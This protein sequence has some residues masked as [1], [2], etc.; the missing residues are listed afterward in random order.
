MSRLDGLA[1]IDAELLLAVAEDQRDDHWHAQAAAATLQRLAHHPRLQGFLP[2]RTVPTGFMVCWFAEQA[3]EA[4]DDVLARLLLA[5]RHLPSELEWHAQQWRRDRRRIRRARGKGLVGHIPAGPPGSG[6]PAQISIGFGAVASTR[7]PPRARSQ[8]PARRAQGRATKALK[9]ASRRSSARSGD[10]GD[11]PAGGSSKE[12]DDEPPLERRCAACV[13]LFAPARPAH[14]LCQPCHSTRRAGYSADY[15]TNRER[16]IGG[17]V[18]AAIW[19]EDEREALVSALY[20]RDLGGR[21]MLDEATVAF[22]RRLLNALITDGAVGYI[23]ADTFVGKC[24]VCGDGLILSFVGYAPRADLRC[25]DGCSEAEIGQV[26]G[27]E[28]RP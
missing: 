17:D 2:A 8:L 1:A 12:G 16:T 21:R 9:G 26:L 22:R 15:L 28:V 11:D 23:T 3:R 4:G 27:L 25:L 7:R 19:A 6:T 14:R 20:P 5:N 13:Q 18:E 24:P 10:S